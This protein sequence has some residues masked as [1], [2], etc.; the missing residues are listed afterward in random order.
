MKKLSYVLILFLF[1]CHLAGAQAVSGSKNKVS[2]DMVKTVHSF[3]TSL[4]DS[5]RKKA[6]Y[7]FESEERY[8]WYFVPRAR[9]GVPFKEM[10]ATQQKAAMAVLQESLSKPGYSK[11]AAIIELEKVLKV[12]ENRPPEDDYRDSG[13]YYFTVFGTP[14]RKEPWGWRIEGH[15]LSLN[16]SSLT[17]EVVSATPLFMGSNP[18]IVPSGPEKGKQILKQEEELARALLQSFTPAQ[19]R[20]VIFNEEAPGDIITSNNRKALLTSKKGLTYAQMTAAQKKLFMQLLDEYLATFREQMT[21]NQKQKINKAGMDN[22]LFAWAGSTQRGEKHYYRILGPTI[23]IEYDNTQN[24]GNHVHTVVRDLA[25]DFGED[26][27][28]KHYE[29]QSHGN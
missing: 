4:P 24:N 23:L 21:E 18:A 25:N 26:I 3:L 17:N 14:S 20:T 15:H 29:Q 28:K 12:L 13:K 27:L 11:A 5:L 7:P 8:N 1:S 2:A 6:T 10:T 16:F 19:L 22:L 9:K